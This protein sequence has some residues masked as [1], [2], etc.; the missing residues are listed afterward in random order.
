MRLSWVVASDLIPNSTC[1]ASVSG[2]SILPSIN[3]NGGDGQL[4]YN[5]EKGS[6]WRSTWVPLQKGN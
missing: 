1:S 5:T 2:P 4:V 3:A 6:A